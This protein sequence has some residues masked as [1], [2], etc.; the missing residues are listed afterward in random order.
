ME[1]IEH[2]FVPV[3]IDKWEKFDNAHFGDEVDR[4]ARKLCKFYFNFS[5][6][7]FSLGLISGTLELKPTQKANIFIGELTVKKSYFSKFNNLVNS[8]GT[9]T[10]AL[11]QKDIVQIT[12]KFM[13]GSLKKQVTSFWTCEPR[14]LKS[15][16]RNE[17]C[18][19]Q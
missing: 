13:K 4:F 14:F 1:K 15:L 16:D 7:T 2:L 9:I 17:C 3:A 11:I 10:V 12:H 18:I 6:N 5:D 8:K 19:V